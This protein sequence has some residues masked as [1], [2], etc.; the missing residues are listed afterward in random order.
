MYFQ[1]ISVC[2]S[3]S[4]SSVRVCV[5][6]W[7]HAVNIQPSYTPQW[8]GSCDAKNS[9]LCG[10]D[11]TGSRVAGFAKYKQSLHHRYTKCIVL[12]DREDPC[13][14]PSILHEVSLP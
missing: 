4:S 10:G 1:C 8:F 5:C 13:Y 6:V 12:I 2:G 3:I 14:S 9:R 7:A 11:E